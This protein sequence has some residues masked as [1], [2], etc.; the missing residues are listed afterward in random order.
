MNRLGLLIG[1][2]TLM[3]MKLRRGGSSLPGMLANKIA[4]NLLGSIRYPDLVIAVTGTNGKTS[5][6][7]LIA[8]IFRA[9]GAE[10]AHNT[11]G[12]N[13]MSGITTAILEKTSFSLRLKA[14]VAVLEIDEANI[15]LVF[16][17]LRPHYLLINNFFRD[18]L[19]RY[20]EL[21]TVIG[22]VSNS[23]QDD[24]ILIINGNDP[25]STKVA[26]DH[27]ANKA[28]YFGVSRTANSTTAEGETRESKHCPVCNEELYYEYYHYSQIGKFNCTNCGFATPSLTA[29]ATEV[30]LPERR[31]T[32][33][34]YDYRSGYDN[35]Y[36]LFN[37]M[38]AITVCQDA[39]VSPEIIASAVEAFEIG[40][41][42]MEKC[43]VGS[44]DTFLN[45]VKNPAGLN[46]T[47][48]HI[49][50][51]PHDQ[52]SVFMALNNQSADSIDTSWIWDAAL[53]K[54]NTDR[55]HTFVCSGDRAYDLAVRLEN[56]G[57]PTDRIVVRTGVEEGLTYL[58]NDTHGHPFVLTNYTPLQP[59]RRAL[60]SFPEN[61]S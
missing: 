48:S 58:R 21:E 7:N 39:G 53:E 18:Q 10:V 49:L 11:R 44:A 38:G 6:A 56:A 36:F 5:T 24:Q 17:Q 33:G 25:L 52:F 27:P 14:D 31:F 23:I 9:N 12:A 45:L 1:K 29:E 42:R 41:G 19:E 54:F 4:P 32:S 57:V 46:Q 2:L 20:G 55:L 26:I 51:Q 13:M 8:E 35:L 28:L 37:I 22:K 30:N 16:R 15:P 61:R 47:I 34:G 40:D 60:A 43:R 50:A 3:A 59:V